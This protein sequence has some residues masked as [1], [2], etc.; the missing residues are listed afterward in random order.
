MTLR[1]RLLFALFSLALTFGVFG[2]GVVAVQRHYLI[3]QVDAQLAGYASSPRLVIGLSGTDRAQV[4]LSEVYVGRLFADGRLV[5]VFSPTDDPDLLPA[6]G[7]GDVLSQPEGRG[8]TAGQ[9]RGVRVVTAPLRTD[10]QAVFAIPTTQVDQAIA[11]LAATLTAG[12]FAVLGVVG[13][14]IWWTYRLGLKPFA[15]LTDAARAITR[16]ERRRRVTPGPSGTEANELARAFNTMLDANQ[17]SEERM[18]RFVA[19][20][21]HE[22]RTPLTTLTGYSSLYTRPATAEGA[23]GLVDTQ[24]IGD[25]MRRINA[26]ATRMTR[27][28]NDLF[29]LNE[30]DAGA[31]GAGAEVDLGAVLRDAAADVRVIQP[32]RPVQVEAGDGLIVTGDQDRLVQA[33]TA[34]TSNALRYTPVTAALT[35]RGFKVGKQRVR[36][37]VSDGGPGIAAAEL[38][39]LYDRF[40]RADPQGHAGGTGIGLT[41]GRAI[42]RAHGGDL[43]AASP[44]PGLGATFTLTVP[45]A[46]A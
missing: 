39:H 41:I 27:I 38:P 25:A 13:L 23:Y 28:V 34:F 7:K 10:V 43:T 6:V 21:S 16:G 9:A 14:V 12:G 35:I 18:R 17:A 45:Q 44:G 32:E 33:V 5:T 2:A 46:A 37:E 26:E 24:G 19:D 1:R 20:A 31:A 30:L 36:V 40:Y 11:Q 42:A 22:L 15:D 8:T 29:L 3:G 4:A